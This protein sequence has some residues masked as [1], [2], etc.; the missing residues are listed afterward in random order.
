LPICRSNLRLCLSLALIR[1]YISIMLNGFLRGLAAP[2]PDRA[3]LGGQLA[4]AALLV[5]LARSDD[6][7][8]LAEKTEIDRI[9][10]ARFGIDSMAAAALRADG[11]ALEADAADTVRFTRA[12]K[13]A[14]PQADRAGVLE[15]MW[16]LVLTDGR[17]DPGEDQ[18]MRLAADLLGISDRDSHLARQRASEH[19]S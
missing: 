4:L 8:E 12:I 2:K 11:E 13:G 17:R 9:L 10:S 5:R 19:L 3:P 16:A 18:M 7:Y 14:V 15:T 1:A 6:H